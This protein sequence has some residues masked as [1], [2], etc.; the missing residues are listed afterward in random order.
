MVI[1]LLIIIVVGLGSYY[2][3][4]FRRNT[5]SA[6]GIL[7]ATPSSY[8]L[9]D[10]PY[11]G[12]IVVKEFKIENGGDED[13]KI[14]SLKTSCGCTT[15][16]LIYRGEKSKKF[17]MHPNTLFWSEEIK[18]D[19]SATLKVFFDPTAH[20]PEGTEPFKRSIWIKSNGSGAS[21]GEVELHI[22]GNVIG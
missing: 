19:D 16:Q 21:N 12:G 15:A 8:D 10:V 9:G 14:T 7:K 2:F 17:G 1:S 22:Q 13:L 18:P 3:M 20:G 6:G 5:A 4:G 11:N